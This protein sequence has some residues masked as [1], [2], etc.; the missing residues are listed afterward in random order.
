MKYLIL[1]LMIGSMNLQASTIESVQEKVELNFTYD[2]ESQ[3]FKDTTFNGYVKI[4][5]ESIDFPQ[6]RQRV[7]LERAI[8]LLDTIIN[9]EEFKRKVIAY[10]RPNGSRSYSKN[11]LWYDTT[12]RLTNEDIY[13]IL[14][15]G[16]EK[17]R[18]HTLSEMNLNI[19]KYKS[20][21]WSVVGK[22]VIGWTS[23]SS[24]ARINVNWRFYD[25][26]EIHQMAGNIMHEWIHLLG[27]LH[28][29]ENAHQEVPYVVGRIAS[30]MAAD[31]IQ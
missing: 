18:P 31:M 27:F 7:K 11:Y 21:W 12:K 8:D 3:K 15:T 1:G 19:K 28:G 2:T 4:L 13:M 23:P 9:S 29:K 30:E 5:K 26:F 14:M 22:K 17:M 25:D 10:T 6:G 24:S 20:P 16:D